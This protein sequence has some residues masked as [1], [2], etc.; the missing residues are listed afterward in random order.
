[1][2]RIPKGQM[3]LFEY[4]AQS[5]KTPEVEE[6]VTLFAENEH[7]FQVKKGSIFEFIVSNETW[8]TKKSGTGYRVCDTN[9]RMHGCIWD[10]NL[11]VDVF[12]N[13]EE[14]EGF[15]F[16]CI[17]F[18]RWKNYK[19]EILKLLNSDF[20]LTIEQENDIIQILKKLEENMLDQKKINDKLQKDT[21]IQ[22]LKNMLKLDGIDY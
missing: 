1:M 5:I 21:T 3:D 17:S 22:A 11:G 14:A 7:V 9:H 15:K 19:Q 4:M 13:K 10:K 6:R 12:K 18:E 2:K 16:E 20:E 8:D